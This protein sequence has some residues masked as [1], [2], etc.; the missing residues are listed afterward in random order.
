MDVF[1]NDPLPFWESLY[2]I[3]KIYAT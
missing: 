2:H 1:W 3:T